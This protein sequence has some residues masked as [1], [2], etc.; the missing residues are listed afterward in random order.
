MKIV[1]K[2]E[3]E[4]KLW[5]TLLAAHYKWEKSKKEETEEI[6]TKK[7]SISPALLL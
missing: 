6:I 4:V 1:L 2:S 7:A 5:E 3:M